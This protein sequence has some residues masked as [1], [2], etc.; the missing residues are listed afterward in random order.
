MPRRIQREAEVV[1]PDK[2]SVTEQ[3]ALNELLRAAEL[4]DWQ[5]VVLNGGHPCFQ[6]E[7]GRFCGRAERWHSDHTHRVIS[8]A[9]LLRRR[10]S[11]AVSQ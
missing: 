10:H 1:M 7:Q 8:L 4:M 6:L 3:S 5:Q 11:P 2:E 9:D